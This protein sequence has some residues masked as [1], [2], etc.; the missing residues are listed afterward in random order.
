MTEEDIQRVEDAFVQAVER[1]KQVGC[2]PSFSTILFTM[3]N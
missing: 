3:R 1:C 2:E